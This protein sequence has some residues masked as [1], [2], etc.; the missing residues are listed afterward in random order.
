MARKRLKPIFEKW[1]III[2]ITFIFFGGGGGGGGEVVDA[3][4][5]AFI[6]QLTVFLSLYLHVK[7]P[8]LISLESNLL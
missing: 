3:Q 4:V 5:K 1:I 7:K 8:S 2:I 6:F